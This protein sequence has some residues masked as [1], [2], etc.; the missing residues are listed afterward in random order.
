MRIQRPK[1]RKAHSFADSQEQPITN[2]SQT[3]LQH[4]ILGQLLVHCCNPNL[5]SLGPLGSD[6]LNTLV[7][8]NNSED[9]DSLCTPFT[10]RLD[11]GGAGS[12]GCNNRIDQD[13]KTTSTATGGVTRDLLGKVVVVLDWVES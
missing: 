6:S 12:T 3:R 13:S 11:S 9:D 1:A 7:S 4:T 10:K 5:A 2:I 8:S